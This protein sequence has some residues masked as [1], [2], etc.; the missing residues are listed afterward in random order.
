MASMMP[1]TAERPTL[2]LVK[3]FVG[4]PLLHVGHMGRLLD[5]SRTSRY[6]VQYMLHTISPCLQPVQRQSGD[7]EITQHTRYCKIRQCNSYL[8][9][10]RLATTGI[11][12]RLM[13]SQAARCCECF[14]LYNRI[15]DKAK[16]YTLHGL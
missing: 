7:S 1:V 15:I 12:I 3:M 8:G 13:S 16:P 5:C 9:V 6:G 11:E 4:L 10:C 2:Q 14:R